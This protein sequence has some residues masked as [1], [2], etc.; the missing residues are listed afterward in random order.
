MRGLAATCA[1]HPSPLTPHPLDTP[2]WLQYNPWIINYSDSMIQ[3]VY[4][5]TTITFDVRQTSHV[6][7]FTMVSHSYSHTSLSYNIS[8]GPNLTHRILR[9]MITCVQCRYMHMSH[10][11]HMMPSGTYWRC[12]QFAP[13]CAASQKQ[14]SWSGRAC[15]L[16]WF[17]R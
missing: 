15:F 7:D 2:P 3:L 16:S 12:R 10:A 13:G 4:K 14:C 9:F 11:H 8:H 5:V 17:V 1:M 6:R